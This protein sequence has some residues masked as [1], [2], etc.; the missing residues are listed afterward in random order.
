MAINLSARTQTTGPVAREVF[1]PNVGYRS[2]LEQ[3]ASGVSQVGRAAGQAASAMQRKDDT[4]AKQLAAT[5]YQVYSTNMGSAYGTLESVTKDPN[6][7]AAQVAE[8][9]SAVE[10]FKTPNYQSMDPSGDADESYYKAYLQ[11]SAAN[12]DSLQLEYDTLVK[13]QRQLKAVKQEISG[14]SNLNSAMNGAATT[15]W[16]IDEIAKVSST[17]DPKSGSG[18]A[19]LNNRDSS[20]KEL[21]RQLDQTVNVTVARMSELPV[22]NQEIELLALKESLTTLSLIDSPH[23]K[24]HTADF[25]KVVNTELAAIGKQGDKARKE[26]EQEHDTSMVNDAKVLAELTVA[27]RDEISG[28]SI[29]KGEA[30]HV[31]SITNSLSEHATQ[32]EIDSQNKAVIDSIV[33]RPN[34]VGVSYVSQAAKNAIESGA[35]TGDVAPTALVVYSPD[36]NREIMNRTDLLQNAEAREHLNKIVSEEVDYIKSGI[37]DNDFSVIGRLDAAFASS[38]KTATNLE[39]DPNTRAEA[40]DAMRFKVDQLRKDPAYKELFTGVRSFGI[41][42]DDNGIPFS[43]MGNTRKLEYLDQMAQLNGREISSLST[44]LRNSGR[45][46]ENTLGVLL[47]LHMDGI[48]GQAL[49]DIDRGTSVYAG[50]SIAVSGKDGEIKLQSSSVTSMYNVI[51]DNK[52]VTP[53]GSHILAARRLGDNDLADMLQKIEASQIAS[54]L[55]INPNATAEEV[56]KNLWEVQD[57]YINSLGNKVTSSNGIVTSI[58]PFDTKNPL[59]KK[60]KKFFQRPSFFTGGRDE[61]YSEAT[62]EVLV[63]ALVAGNIDSTPFLEMLALSENNPALRTALSGESVDRKEEAIKF[64]RG[65]NERTSALG[66]PYV[67]YSNVETIG[68]VD[69]IIPRFKEYGSDKYRAFVDKKTGNLL[70]LPYNGIHKSVSETLEKE[71]KFKDK[72]FKPLQFLSGATLSNI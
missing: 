29:P 69:Y 60:L 32:S 45:G 57:S 55:G 15:S 11:R 33:Y 63:D 66:V 62:S 58:P 7:T 44:S 37:A 31:H 26:R 5:N 72:L 25:L 70:R 42:P 2:G 40:W 14:Y 53:L 19:L 12:R 39:L 6:S 47:D 18:I 17:Y 34:S 41:M 9:R 23:A 51:R 27:N 56:H 67:D 61:R 36:G 1:D 4:A 68:G 59:H 10:A 3:V 20:D 38:W 52:S 65:L 24:K 28:T 71:A 48:S 49:E 35:L 46:S 43:E 30:K 21:Y 54:S 64:A 22:F 50:S 16:A 13:S 8:A